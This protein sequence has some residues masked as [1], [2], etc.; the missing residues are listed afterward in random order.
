MATP[1]GDES[2]HSRGHP[3]PFT[4]ADFWRW[5]VADLSANAIRGL[6][7]EFL[8][9]RALV[10]ASAAARVEWDAV[11]LLTSRGTAIEVKCSGH[12]QSWAQA[13]LSRPSFDIAPKRGWSAA[14]NTYAAAATRPARL[15]VFA[16][17]HHKE[18]DTLDV[19]DVSQWSFFVV[20]TPLLDTKHPSTKRL[21]LASV[22]TLSGSAVRYEELAVR[23][24]SQELQLAGDG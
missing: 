21:S 3:L 9:A 11:D 22:I 7:A 10:G 15:Y 19:Q 18:R 16:L 14:T 12:V 23:V 4:V 6:V 13:S 17:H 2:F 8:V 20:P 24:L 1:T 5:A